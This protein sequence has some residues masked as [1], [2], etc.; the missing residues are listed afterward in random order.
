MS[1]TGDA[2]APATHGGSTES[3]TKADR[4]ARETAQH[5]RRRKLL[6]WLGVALL[7]LL[8]AA[9]IT[10]GVLVSQDV[11]RTGS[12]E[13]SSDRSETAEQS[14]RPSADVQDETEKEATAGGDIA[15]T[16]TSHS[17]SSTSATSSS[18]SKTASVS[19]KPT[20]TSSCPSKKNIPSSARGTDLDT[21]TWLS[22]TDFNCTFTSETVGDLPLVGLFSKWDD[23]ARANPN[24]PALDRPWGDYSARPARGV[25]VGGWLSL[26]PFI[27]PSMFDYPD[28]ARVVDE[29]TLCQHLGDK[30]SEVLEKH[31]ATFITEKDFKQIATAGLDHVRIP[32]SYWAIETFDD[33]A[34][35]P[36]ISWRYLLRGI[37]W[38]RKYGLRVKL[39]LHGLPGSQNG[40]NHSGRSGKIN[41]L[42]GAKGDIN[43]Q[44]ALDIHERLSKFFAQDRYKNV[45]AFYGLANEPARA[46]DSDKVEEWTKKAVDIVLKNKVHGAPVFSEGLLGLSAWEGKFG[47]YKK[48]KLVVDVHQYTIFDTNLLILKPADRVTFA[49]DKFAEQSSDSMKNFG[50]T[51]VGEWSQAHSDCTKDLNGF[52][53]GS[54]WAGDFPDVDG[55]SCPSQDSRCTC[56]VSNDENK[57]TDAYKLFI[58]TWAIAQ[59]DAYEKGTG[60]FYWTWKTESAPMWS[61]KHGLD[62][63]FLPKKA[64]ERDWDCSQ[65]MPSFDG[66]KIYE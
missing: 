37:E 16:T 27:T 24:V 63:G 48:S 7:A 36:R 60:W 34:Y 18:P 40:W 58:K 52:N 26:E 1:Q 4:S 12:S 29:Y 43:A 20:S 59:M 3:L 19:S 46:L 9:G 25:N 14:S 10:V 31:Y 65:D 50:P 32:F 41:F 35:V 54:R 30:A 13:S 56:S 38:A 33:D 53:A 61:Y 23:S 55:P 22:M 28:S 39:D 62:G 11:I 64:Y 44:R 57:Y 5:A 66:V 47:E 2:A 15:S 17:P 42:K 21:T 6:T 49:C 51:M 45:I 8:I